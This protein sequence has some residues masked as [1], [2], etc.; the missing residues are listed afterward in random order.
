MQRL[1]EN[2]FHLSNNKEIKL[3]YNF[4]STIE[5]DCFENLRQPPLSY[6]SALT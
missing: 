1:N 4:V 2:K 5:R 6:F 3:K